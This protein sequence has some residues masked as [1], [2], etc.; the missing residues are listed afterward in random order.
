M[1]K[2]EYYFSVFF[3]FIKN[4]INTGKILFLLE[5]IYFYFCNKIGKN[6]IDNTMTVYIR[7][8]NR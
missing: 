6:S 1:A 2:T 3:N 4:S 8:I 5:I 7:N